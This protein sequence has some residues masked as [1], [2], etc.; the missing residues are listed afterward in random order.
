MAY[1]MTALPPHHRFLIKASG[2]KHISGGHL[3][4]QPCPTVLWGVSASVRSAQPELHTRL[5]HPGRS[6]RCLHILIASHNTIRAVI[7]LP[8]LQASMQN[9]YLD[10][11]AMY[12]GYQLMGECIRPSK[13]LC[14]AVSSSVLPCS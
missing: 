6:R 12:S 7:T 14:T 4:L 2:S 3:E 8:V 13:T 1:I 9:P 5:F 10:M 11:C